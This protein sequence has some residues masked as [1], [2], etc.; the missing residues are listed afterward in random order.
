MSTNTEVFYAFANRHADEGSAVRVEDTPFGVVLYSYATPIAF[1]TSDAEVPVFT[2]RKFSVTTSKQ[3]SQ[4]RRIAGAY[5]DL[6]DAEFRIQATRIGASF[7][8]AR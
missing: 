1:F 4:A 2:T 7:A 5:T 8:L 6:D 3:Q